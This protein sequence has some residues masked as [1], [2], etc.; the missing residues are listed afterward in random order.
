MSQL[1][2]LVA[3]KQRWWEHTTFIIQ[4][5]RV[6]YGSSAFFIVNKHSGGGGGVGGVTHARNPPSFADGVSF[7]PF[8]ISLSMNER[9]AFVCY[10]QGRRGGNRGERGD[11]SLWHFG[12]RSRTTRARRRRRYRIWLRS[13]SSEAVINKTGVL[14]LLLRV[15]VAFFS[16]GRRRRGFE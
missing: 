14:P 1:A 8:F 2:S 4:M 16:W 13:S 11:F 3:V 6:P 15:D 10:Q 5:V 7:H 12:V 9:N